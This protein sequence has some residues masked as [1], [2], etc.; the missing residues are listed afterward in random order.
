MADPL[1]RY[2]PRLCARARAFEFSARGIFGLSGGTE[3]PA[4]VRGRPRVVVGL[5]LSLAGALESEMENVS[6]MESKRT[7]FFGCW[8]FFVRGQ[9][10][11]MPGSVG[12]V[13]GIFGARFAA[14]SPGTASIRVHFRLHFTGHSRLTRRGA[15]SRDRELR[16]GAPTLSQMDPRAGR[17][18]TRM[19][20]SRIYQLIRHTSR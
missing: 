8:A 6:T 18:V 12:V 3:R 11:H 17:F 4:G 20:S 14:T 15:R 19:Y 16:S 1:S 2:V 13:G 10:E 9:S 5:T 7:S